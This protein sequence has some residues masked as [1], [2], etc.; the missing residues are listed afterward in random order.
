MVLALAALGLVT[1][2]L[3]SKFRPYAY[4]LAYVMSAFVTPGD[5]VLVALSL[6]VPLCALYELSVVL[7]KIVFRKRQ[8]RAFSDNATESLA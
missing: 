7:A 5:F 4:V 1:P 6:A 3:L 2:A 8:Q